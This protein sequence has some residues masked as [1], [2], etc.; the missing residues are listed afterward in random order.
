MGF[1]R[2]CEADPVCGSVECRLALAPYWSEKLGKNDFKACISLFSQYAV[3]VIQ[4]IVCLQ[5][6]PRGGILELHFDEENQRMLISGKAVTVMECSLS[7]S[8]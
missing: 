2:P 4:D 3:C 8:A 7:L 6:S 1:V 5:A